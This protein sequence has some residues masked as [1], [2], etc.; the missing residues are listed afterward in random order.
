M[1]G[2][3][4][5]CCGPIPRLMALLPKLG[6]V[7]R[8]ADWRELALG[9]VPGR[10]LF[11]IGVDGFGPGPEAADLLRFIRCSQDRFLNCVAGVALE[12][13]GELDTKDLGRRLIFHLNRA[14]CAFPERPLE[15][16][17][18]SLHNLAALKKRLGLADLEEA[19]TAALDGLCLRVQA[20]SPQRYEKP[21]VLM[22]HAS[23]R[24]TSNTLALGELIVSRLREAFS[25]QAMSLRN[26]TIE[27]CRGCSYKV[28][29]HYASRGACFYGG[30]IATEVIPAVQA[31]DILLLLLPNYN[32]AVGANIMAFINRLT[33]LHVSGA[34][35][36]KT[37]FAVVVSGYSG[38]D[39]VAEQA[40]GALCLNKSF[41]LPP[42]FCML[43]T[44][45]DP[46]EVLRL[47]GIGE[48]AEEFA[49]RIKAC[50]LDA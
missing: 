11:A 38:G 48:R 21:R 8:L 35:T 37:L 47:P 30:S 16:G 27:D 22:L 6:S 5:Y 41:L 19:W 45:G 28:C 29:T 12:G 32:D 2:L 18:G 14:G 40:M 33:S 31:S 15:E 36:G 34:L 4:V 13:A 46:G 3:T 10:I 7:D 50:A 49:S 25:V 43:E 1:S 24:A 17:T 23:E 20:F 44:A 39:L 26:G 9:Q 42:R